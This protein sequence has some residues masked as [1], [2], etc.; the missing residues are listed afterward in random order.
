MRSICRTGGRLL[1]LLAI[2]AA[3]TAACVAPAGATDLPLDGA[4]NLAVTDNYAYWEARGPAKC[5]GCDDLWRARLDTG[6]KE[7]VLRY[8]H[9]KILRLA[10]SGN[11]VTFTLGRNGRVYRSQIKVLTEAGD[12]R[13]IASASFRKRSKSNCG[14][15][16][17]AGAVAPGGEVAWQEIRVSTKVKSCGVLPNTLH[18]GTYAG[19]IDR[20]TRLLRAIQRDV[21]SD[22][23]NYAFRGF[24]RIVGFDGRLVLTT[25]YGASIFDSATGGSSPLLPKGYSEFGMTP[26][27]GPNGEVAMTAWADLDDTPLLDREDLILFPTPLNPK[28]NKIVVTPPGDLWATSFCGRHIVQVLVTDAGILVVRRNAA[29]EFVEQRMYPTPG[30]VE[31]LFFDCNGEVGILHELYVKGSDFEWHAFS[32]PLSPLGP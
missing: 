13:T 5:P 30:R 14:G 25:G 20:P 4:G 21:F 16:V 7:R 26:S 1:A 10:G 31:D 12:L 29:T 32:F 15:F 22:R 28:V 2:C 19:G 11:T 27:L 18:F 24:Q 23:W 8:R 9:G 17:E 3:A 6:V